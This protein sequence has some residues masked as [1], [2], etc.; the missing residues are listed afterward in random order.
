MRDRRGS[1]YYLGI[2]ICSF[3]NIKTCNKFSAQVDSLHAGYLGLAAYIGCAVL[4]TWC[5]RK[6]VSVNALP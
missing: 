1:L 6:A 5:I 3:V 2:V 4:L